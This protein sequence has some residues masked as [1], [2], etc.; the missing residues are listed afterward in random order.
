M[1]LMTE[2]VAKHNS[3]IE[4]RPQFLNLLVYMNETTQLSIF[5]NQ[6]K[7]DIYISWQVFAEISLDFF[8]FF[9]ICSTL[10]HFCSRA[11]GHLEILFLLFPP[12]C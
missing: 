7:R 9:C 4:V 11:Q 5:Q 8:F 2:S 3:R 6:N 1:L 10:M 12:L